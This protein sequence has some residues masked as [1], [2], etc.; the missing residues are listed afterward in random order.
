MCMKQRITDEQFLSLSLEQSL[1]LM[2]ILGYPQKDVS[3]K[4]YYD[5]KHIIGRRFSHIIEKIN[6]GKMYE[7]LEDKTTHSQQVINEGGRYSIEVNIKGL[8]TTGWQTEYY[9]EI[10]DALWEAV[11]HLI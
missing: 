8:N 4:F 3:A 1:K 5:N 11:V 2:E 7:I 6:I 9:N 10:C